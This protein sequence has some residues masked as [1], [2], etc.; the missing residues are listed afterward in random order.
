MEVNGSQ[1]FGY[2]SPTSVFCVI[3]QVCNDMKASKS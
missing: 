3:K 2:Y 1:L